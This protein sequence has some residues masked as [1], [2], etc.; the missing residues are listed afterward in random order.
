MTPATRWRK[1]AGCEIAGYEIAGYIDTAGAFICCRDL[2]APSGPVR[3]QLT[4]G[5]TVVRSDCVEV[6]LGDGSVA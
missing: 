4:G 6:Y 5:G 2:I 1:F 3:R